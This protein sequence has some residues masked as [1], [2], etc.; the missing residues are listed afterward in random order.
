MNEALDVILPLLGG[1]IVSKKTDWFEV[2]EAQIQ[3]PCYTQPH[4]NGSSR[5]RSPSG[6]LAQ[7]NTVSECYQLEEHQMM[8]S[9]ITLTIGK[10]VK[11]QP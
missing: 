10:F 3:L 1:E 9:L 4:R 8:H 5:A 6:A 11:R 7:L 2:R